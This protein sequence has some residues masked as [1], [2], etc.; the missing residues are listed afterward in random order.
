MLALCVLTLL[1]LQLSF[2]ATLSLKDAA[3]YALRHSPALDTSQRQALI[4]EDERLN[5]RAAFLPTLDFTSAHGLARTHA[6][7]GT[8]SPNEPWSSS[9]SLNLTETLYDNGESITRHRIAGIQEEIAREALLRDRDRL[10]LDVATAFYQHSVAQKSLEIQKEQHAVLKLQVDLVKQSYRQGVKSRKDFLRFQTQLNRSDIDLL[11]AR[12][13]LQKT[14][15]SLRRL[16]GVPLGSGETLEFAVDEA[17]PPPQRFT[18]TRLEA[19]RDNRVAELQRRV[20]DLNTELARRR[21]W[22]EVGV[23]T[24]ATYGSTDYW[25]TGTRAHEND[26]LSWS[27]LLT[28]KY[29]ILDWGVRRRNAEIAASRAH[30]RSNELDT[31]LFGLRE[32]MEKLAVDLRKIQ[33]SFLL[34]DELYKLERANLSLITNEYRQGKVEYL[35]YINTLQNFASAKLNY[36]S[37]LYELKRAILARRYHEGTIHEVILNE[38]DQRK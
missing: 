37:S 30:I 6:S 22:P 18:E 3:A 29:N 8:R 31:E 2:A 35:D 33:E 36:Y 17:R 5:A 20:A 14:E 27:A 10:L 21:L 26:R 16:L 12:T 32:E 38:A 13:N 34:T 28:V 25:N 9:F 19:H 23:V 4:A 15:L 7:T 24:S 1:N 11:A